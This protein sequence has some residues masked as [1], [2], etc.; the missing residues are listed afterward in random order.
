MTFQVRVKL[1]RR[2]PLRVVVMT[3]GQAVIAVVKVPILV[4]LLVG[5][6]T[7]PLRNEANGSATVDG[8]Q[9]AC[10]PPTPSETA[11]AIDLVW[12]TTWELVNSPTPRVDWICGCESVGTGCTDY[13]AFANETIR[14]RAVGAISDSFFVDALF[15]YRKA[16]GLPGREDERAAAERALLDAGY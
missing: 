3:L 4:A 13:W 12:R 16:V 11:L 10:R 2:G 1:V 7:R 8:G 9:I 14:V 5:C 15:A 6:D